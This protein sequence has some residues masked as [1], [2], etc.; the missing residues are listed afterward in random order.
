M[1]IVITAGQRGDSP[2]FA[3]VLAGIR[4]PRTGPGRPRRRPGRVLATRLT[5]PGPTAPPAAAGD[6]RTIPTKLTRSATAEQVGGGRP[7]AFDPERYKLRHAVECGINR[8]KGNRAVATRYD[9]LACLYQA[10]VHIA[11]INDWLPP[12][13]ETRPSVLRLKLA[14]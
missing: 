4:V 13:F 9:K 3:A 8:L 14:I 12:T 7:P 10:T 6:P 11:A 5:A 1:S 2:Q